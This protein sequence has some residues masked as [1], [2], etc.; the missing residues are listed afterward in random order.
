MNNVTLLGRLVKDPELRSTQSGT[1][2]ASFTIAVDREYSKDKE[3]ETDFIPCVA[4]KGAGET[5][6]KFFHK[7][8]RILVAGKLQTRSY[9]DKEG[10]KRTAFE[11]VVRDFDFIEKRESGS[12]E[13]YAVI[14]DDGDLPF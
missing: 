6:A 7:G 12:A 1:A 11:V 3:R 8:Q 10:N 13:D 2:V 4:W 9:T 14:E 5:I